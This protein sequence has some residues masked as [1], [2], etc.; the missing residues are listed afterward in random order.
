MKPFSTWRTT[1]ES[2]SA[3]TS[4]R[5]NHRE[6][7]GFQRER[8]RKRQS[9]NS[10]ASR[11]GGGYFQEM[12]NKEILLSPN[13]RLTMR[14]GVSSALDTILSVKLV[15]NTDTIPKEVRWTN[16]PLNFNRE[17]LSNLAKLME[18]RYGVQIIINSENLK[19]QRFTGSITDENLTEMLDA[20]RLSYPFEYTIDNKIITIKPQ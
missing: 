18:N 14:N 6:R 19:S 12:K 11:V 5:G 13:Q 16:Q 4:K 9:G 15:E 8:Q 17:K 3:C 20:L 10:P 1:P 7:N 2:L